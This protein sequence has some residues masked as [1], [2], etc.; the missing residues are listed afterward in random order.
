MYFYFTEFDEVEYSMR[1]YSN[2]L[3]DGDAVFSISVYHRLYIEVGTPFQCSPFSTNLILGSG[4]MSEA[5]V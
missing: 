4:K 2:L 3:P 5:A 1:L